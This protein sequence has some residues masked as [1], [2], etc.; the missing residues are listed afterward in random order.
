[1]PRRF[2]R[3]YNVTTQ[4]TLSPGVA[5][6]TIA[7]T[8]TS[9]WEGAKIDKVILCQSVVGVGTGT[10]DLKLQKAGGSVDVT[11]TLSAVDADAVIGKEVG[12]MTGNGTIVDGPL[13]LDVVENGTVSTTAQI[14]FMVYW[15]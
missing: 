15:S 4:E 9:P 1:M 10:Y 6:G 5:T 13:E 14:S 8:M 3:P 7:S 12:V 2:M 11:D